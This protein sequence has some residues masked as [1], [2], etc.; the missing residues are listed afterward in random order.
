MTHAM[1]HT[2][3]RRSTRYTAA[4]ALS[5]TL[6]S[7]ACTSESPND[8]LGSGGNA[9]AAGAPSHGGGGATAQG[10]SAP[11]SGG[12][13]PAGAGASGAGQAGS[14]GIHA[15]NGGGSATAG[16][17]G[18]RPSGGRAG[19]SGSTSAGGRGGSAG[20][21]SA[22]GDDG[23]DAGA[24]NGESGAAGDP[25]SERPGWE[26]VFSDE[27]E[28]AKGT[29]VD[30]K[31]WNLVNKGDGFGNNELQ[32]YTNRTDNAA[33]D[34]EGSLVI[35]AIE[36]SY[37]GR[38]YTSARLESN[39][40]VELTYGR[41]ESRM[42]IPYGQG[43]WPAFWML[44]TD[45]DSAGW[46]D[47]GEIDIMENVGKE[48][49]TVHGTL[50]GPGYSGG[51]PLGASYSLPGNARFADDFHVYAVEWEKDVVRFYVDDTLY[52]TRTPADVPSG[53]HWVYDHSFYLLLNVAVGGQWPGSPNSSTTF[54]QTLTVDYVRV[55]GRP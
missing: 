16:A 9:S 24:V 21:Q 54:P 49:T 3:S 13:G 51:S 40:K 52:K 30:T 32:Y 27:F 11:G 23:N 46:P 5:L 38:D 19:S 42:R 33:L 29:A 18:T 47:C 31:N 35:K 34:G 36:E 37:M 39:G 50:H 48:P 53:A 25:T 44:G 6:L 14:G 15:G 55:Y 20:S 8:G 28:G 26:L 4:S 2:S 7:L 45:I 22:G 17:S 12:A 1:T 43:L 10:G 41:V